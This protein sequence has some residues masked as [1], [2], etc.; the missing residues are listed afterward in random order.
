M[1]S[2]SLSENHPRTHRKFC[3]SRE[4]MIQSSDRRWLMAQM[5]KDRAQIQLYRMDG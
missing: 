5:Q 4:V 2:R 3:A 1:R